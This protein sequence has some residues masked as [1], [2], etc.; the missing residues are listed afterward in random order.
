M[1]RIAN[2]GYKNISYLENIT[3][4]SHWYIVQ[5]VHKTLRY[6]GS[7]QTLDEAFVFRGKLYAMVGRIF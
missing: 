3:K 4:T 2:T 1:V 6:S 7:F 5:M